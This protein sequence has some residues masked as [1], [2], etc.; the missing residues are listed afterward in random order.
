[1]CVCVCVCVCTSELS[2]DRG[3]L[4]PHG[5][6]IY[7]VCAYALFARRVKYIS[8]YLR[9]KLYLYILCAYIFYTYL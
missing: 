6:S 5:C 8:T 7:S 2:G 4:F 1:M 3:C 9:I